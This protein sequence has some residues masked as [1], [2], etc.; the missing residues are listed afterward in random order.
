M[1][2]LLIP[3]FGAGTEVQTSST[4]SCESDAVEMGAP[5]ENR[6]FLCI[7]AAHGGNTQIILMSVPYLLRY[8]LG[9]ENV[10]WHLVT[11]A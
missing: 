1:I 10:V 4:C 3:R 7:C 11:V 2:E 6:C 5:F 8:S 9:W